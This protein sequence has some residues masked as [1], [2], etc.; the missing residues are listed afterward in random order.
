M[1]EVDFLDALPILAF[2]GVMSYVFM[3]EE[4]RIARNNSIGYTLMIVIIMTYM[5]CWY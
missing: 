4:M 2:V 1:D 5:F 3:H